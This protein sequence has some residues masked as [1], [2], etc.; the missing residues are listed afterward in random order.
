MLFHSSHVISTDDYP[1]LIMPSHETVQWELERTIRSARWG[2]EPLVVVALVNQSCPTLLQPMDC[3]PPGSSVH[4]I[5]Q[6][7]ILEWVAIPFSRGSSQPRDRTQVPCIVGGFFTSWATRE[8]QECWSG[9]PLPSPADHLLGF[10]H[11]VLVAFRDNFFHSVKQHEHDFF[12]LK[13]VIP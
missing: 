1:V 2:R 10:C 7:R 13:T 3:G 5:L 6:A 8:A 11:P 4:G 12:V 9:Q